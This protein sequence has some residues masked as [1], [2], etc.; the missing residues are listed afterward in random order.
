MK[1]WNCEHA[2]KFHNA[3]R[4]IAGMKYEKVGRVSSQSVLKCTGKDWDQWA[5]ILTNQGAAQWTHKEIVAFLKKKHKLSL[6]WQQ[7]VTTGYEMII[8]RKIEGRNAKGE[9]S[10]TAGKT[11]AIDAKV[12]WKFLFSPKGLQAWLKPLSGFKLE[13]GFTYE[14]EGGVYGQV[15]TFKSPERLRMTWQE[16]DGDK[17]MVVQL[18]VHKRPNGK[19]AIWIV[20]EK[21]RDGREK[22]RLRA[23][24]KMALE[25]LLQQF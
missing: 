21:I 7:G 9:Y 14:T 12:L 18:Y 3:S 17:A 24:W 25:E 10:V 1:T 11:I 6:W 19:S 4:K 20:H 2:L 15:R 23:H 13:K 5:E 8:G 22:N 16:S